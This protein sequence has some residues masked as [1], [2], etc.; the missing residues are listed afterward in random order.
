[1][2][3]IDIRY[4][5]KGLAI[6]FLVISILGVLFG[7]YG[8]ENDLFSS[9]HNDRSCYYSYYDQVERSLY[10]EGAGKL[11]HYYIDDTSS[12]RFISSYVRSYKIA[13]YPFTEEYKKHS[14]KVVLDM[15]EH[16]G[17][18]EEYGSYGAA[19][20]A[21]R[22]HDISNPRINVNI[23]EE[24]IYNTYYLTND[25][26][27]DEF[28]PQDVADY[29]K[30][31]KTNIV[32]SGVWENGSLK[33]TRDINE[34]RAQDIPYATN[35]KQAIREV[36]SSIG[37]NGI[38]KLNFTYSINTE[39]NAFK[40]Y[41]LAMNY[42]EKIFPNSALGVAAGIVLILILGLFSSYEK[43]KESRF[44]ISILKIPVEMVIF[45]AVPLWLMCGAMAADFFSRHTELTTGIVSPFYLLQVVAIITMGVAV[46]YLLYA[47][48]DVFY[49]GFSST[50]VKNSIVSKILNF[51]RE[52]SVGFFRK[53]KNV[54][55]EYL[56]DFDPG[57]K[58][59][60]M[61]FFLVLFILGI[62]AANIVV[63][64]HF[65]LI[66]LILW[67][68]LLSVIFIRVQKYTSE[69]EDI[70][71]TAKIISEGHYDI[72]IEEGNSNF[73][74]LAHNLNLIT[75][76]LDSAISNAVK[77]EKLK[78]DLIANV[79][80]DLKTPLT[81][82]INYSELIVNEEDVE[83]IKKY[84]GVINEKSLKLKNLIEDLFEAAKVSSDNIDLEI[85]EIDFKQ[86]I[87]QIIGEWEDKL[88]EKNLSIVEEYTPESVMLNLDGVKTSRIL[89]NLFS[90]I[91]KYALEG[92]RIYLTLEK[93]EN[94]V[95]TIKNISK[96]PLNI[97]EDELMER[98]KRGD[99]SR[100][101]E[102]SGLGLSIAQSLVKAQKGN[103]EIEIDGDLF[104]SKIEF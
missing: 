64:R 22:E 52:K 50:I 59:N 35:L 63:V 91:Y 1:M 86:L 48:K 18:F 79:S 83:N 103:F 71:K 23:T 65:Q 21:A 30:T 93:K 5:S 37:N 2:S 102:G 45:V 104:K 97:S 90:N 89:D 36:Y 66:V 19:I 4:S 39:S 15:T 38:Q 69:L 77:S 68:V 96:F 14:N 56:K 25:S 10:K 12:D 7:I 9:Y 33:F 87:K 34:I 76:N 62:V 73:K 101:T 81:S 16:D 57:K 49:K 42:E 51:F 3:D 92:T 11:N 98:F 47:L 70:E 53:S 27:I 40:Q 88:E 26:G 85:E 78:T 94:V 13:N 58:R 29:L 84:S 41:I 32:I 44:Y 80:H 99:V 82:I 60:L 20:D 24:P 6:I 43:M 17:G 75:S 31:A 100:N 54:S 67:T 8:S 74:G 28:D 46:L 61:L 55:N 95:L 72:K